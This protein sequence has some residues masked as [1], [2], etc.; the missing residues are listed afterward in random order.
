MY[1][2]HYYHQQNMFRFQNFLGKLV[3]M[4]RLS[5]N[6]GGVQAIHFRLL[7]CQK[8]KVLHGGQIVKQR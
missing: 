4:H 1:V 8:W 6:F 5:S 3:Q 7:W 2:C